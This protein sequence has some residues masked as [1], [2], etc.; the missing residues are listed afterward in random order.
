MAEQRRRPPWWMHLVL[1]LCTAYFLLFCSVLA[2]GPEAIGFGAVDS[3]GVIRSV[4][5]GLAA[6]RADLREGDTLLSVNG[7][8]GRALWREIAH[9][10][11]GRRYDLLVRRGGVEQTISFTL[12]KKDLR[13]LTDPLG[14]VLV[15]NVPIWALGIALAW[16]I[17]WRR[18]G[19]ATA[20]LAALMQAAGTPL[21]NHA[22][23]LL[24]APGLPGVIAR[25]PVPLAAIPLAGAVGAPIVALVATTMFL[26]SFPRPLLR[27]HWV[28]APLWLFAALLGWMSWVFVYNLVYWPTVRYASPTWFRTTVGPL[29]MLLLAALVLSWPFLLAWNYR[30]LQS[31]NDRRR[32]RVLVAGMAL[33]F[34]VAGFHFF[35]VSAGFFGS[36]AANSWR[37]RLTVAYWTSPFR[38]L[39]LLMQAA[40]PLALAYAVLRHRVL[41]V[42]V[43]LRQGLQYAVARSALS[44][45]SRRSSA[46]PSSPTSPC[47]PTRRWPRCSSRAGGSTPS[48]PPPPSSPT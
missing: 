5:V 26:A 46:S 29:V 37:F 34:L 12:G 27:G 16:L 8:T 14:R 10:W 9:G 6:D 41:D 22:F 40:G 43:L 4:Q 3:S 21:L 32:T 11:V 7:Q 39:G 18:P 35:L 30:G 42:G 36:E 13:Y 1:V 48:S 23:F 47:T 2:F 24:L 31:P 28:W 15:A 19:D 17:A 33:S 38:L 20:R 44:W 25:L 45:P